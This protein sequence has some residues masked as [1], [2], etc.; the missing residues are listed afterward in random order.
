MTYTE[1]TEQ[2]NAESRVLVELDIGQN[3]V[4]WVNA[5]AGIWLCDFDNVYTYVDSS[6][7]PASWAVIDVADI[8]SLQV[9]SLPYLRV[10][11]LADVTTNNTSYYWDRTT[12]QVY[13]HMIDNESPAMHTLTLGV[14]YGYSQSE[15]T[16]VDAPQLYE[17]RLVDIPSFGVAR[18]PLFFGRL[19]FPGFTIQLVNGDGEFDTFAEDNDIYG[20]E[21]RVKHGYAALDY[22]DY[23]T[24]YTGTIGSIEVSEERVSITIEDRRAKLKR[25]VA[26]SCTDKNALEAIRE[27]LLDNYSIPYTSVFYDTTAWATA[28]AAAPN[29]T[30]AEDDEE[31]IQII[32]K[33]CT[34]VFG[35][36]STTTGGLYTFRFVDTSATA[37]TTIQRADI[38]NRIAVAY[39]PSEVVSSVKITYNDEEYVDDTRETDVFTQYRV[40]NEREFDTYSPD[41]TAA[42]VLSTAILDYTDEV[43]GTLK[44]ET[45]LRYYDVEVGDMVTVELY[46]SVNE[47]LGSKTAE[48]TSVQY[49]L[50]RPGMNLGVRFV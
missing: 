42:S 45:P 1:Y 34:S 19:S 4:Q 47:M 48:V 28:E 41:A 21:C 11:T 20:N 5:G 35:F 40:Y 12:K 2:S 16:P 25:K 7:I 31:V 27:L 14:L 23:E 22:D 38:T 9:D 15:F 10:S 13:V 26:Y 18:D 49:L 43:H 46:R 44:L 33:I 39:D 36:F 30:I 3:T 37:G 50:D 8:G 32:E 6:L 17:G 29:V 24:L